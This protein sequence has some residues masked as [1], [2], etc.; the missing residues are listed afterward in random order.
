MNMQCIIDPNDNKSYKCIMESDDK[1]T[2]SSC[3]AFLPI[4]WPKKEDYTNSQDY[5]IDCCKCSLYFRNCCLCGAMNNCNSLNQ[6]L[7]SLYC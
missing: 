3:N 5:L 4:T 6:R 1:S 2:M 7:S